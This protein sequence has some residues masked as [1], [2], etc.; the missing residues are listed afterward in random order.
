MRQLIGNIRG[1]DRLNA[2]LR[3]F[4]NQD[5]EG[6]ARLA[7]INWAI[8]HHQHPFSKQHDGISIGIDAD[9][10]PVSVA[11]ALTNEVSAI[12][13]YHQEVSPKPMENRRPA[14]LDYVLPT[15]EY[16]WG[17]GP[18]HVDIIP[19]GVGE[20]LYDMVVNIDQEPVGSSHIFTQ[21]ILALTSPESTDESIYREISAIQ[22][23]SVWGTNPHDWLMNEGQIMLTMA[24]R[25]FICL[26]P[27]L[28]DETDTH[29]PYNTDDENTTMEESDNEYTNNHDETT[30]KNPNTEGRTQKENK[31]IRKETQPF[32][33]QTS[34]RTNTTLDPRPVIGTSQILYPSPSGEGIAGPPS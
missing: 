7:K 16:G 9:H 28:D 8:R 29:E 24:E 31:A 12:L 30:P 20:H 6:T 23:I 2:T 5:Y 21:A 19:T 33:P 27:D 1:G 25:G 15:C 22:N 13:G 17:D 18:Q 34:Q 14:T 32:T 10:N 3:A 11:Q 26:E 4:T